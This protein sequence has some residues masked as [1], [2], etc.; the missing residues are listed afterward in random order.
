MMGSF[1]TGLFL[2]SSSKRVI[3]QGQEGEENPFMAIG[4]RTKYILDCALPIVGWSLWPIM[5]RRIRMIVNS[6]LH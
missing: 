3:G 2:V 1:F 6:S 4:L 5:D